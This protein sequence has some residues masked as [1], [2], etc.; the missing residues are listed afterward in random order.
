MIRRRLM[1]ALFGATAAPQAW[2]QSA[3]DLQL[4]L[5]V[6]ASGSVDRERFELQKRGYANA[7][8]DPTVLQAIRST[9]TQSIAATMMQWTGPELHVQVVSWS[10]LDDE[11]SIRAF[12][13]AIDAAPRK[14]F[15]GGTSISGAIDNSRDLLAHSP[16]QGSRRIIDISGD[17]ANN[18]G[19]PADEARDEAVAAGV[20][21]NGLPILTLEPDLADFYSEN[22]IGGPG[23]FVIAIDNYDQFAQAILRKLVTEIAAT[24]VARSVAQR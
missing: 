11:A 1:L 7:F 13:G 19:R 9:S 10:R 5:A 21:I 12:A 2:A 24:P 20:S 3:V 22:V 8:R 18:R 15:G 6:D 23:A 4:V 16:F 17:G 14:L